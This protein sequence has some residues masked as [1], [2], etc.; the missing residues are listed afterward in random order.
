MQRE[1][2][3]EAEGFRQKIAELTSIID[4]REDVNDNYTKEI[5]SLREANK[6][7]D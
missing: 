7:Q 3:E 6:R 2:A 5:E 4:S 1:R